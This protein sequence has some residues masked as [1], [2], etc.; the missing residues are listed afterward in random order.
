MEL[1][2]ILSVYLDVTILKIGITYFMKHFR[3]IVHPV[4]RLVRQLLLVV[5]AM[6]KHQDFGIFGGQSDIITALMFY[7][8]LCR[9]SNQLV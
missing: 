1:I 5:Q 2:P 6:A 7:I 3:V 8:L 9:K 4:T